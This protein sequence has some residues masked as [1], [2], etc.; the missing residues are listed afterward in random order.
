[1]ARRVTGA[2]NSTFDIDVKMA[3]VPASPPAREFLFQVYYD[4]TVIGFDSVVAYVPGLP[5]PV[6]AFIDGSNS[7]TLGN[8]TWVGFEI[9]S[10]IVCGGY[11]CEIPRLVR[12]L[13]NLALA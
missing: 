5:A 6:A 4:N 3:G 10:D 7:G 1:I 13:T 12:A 2:A 9:I 8:V 11:S